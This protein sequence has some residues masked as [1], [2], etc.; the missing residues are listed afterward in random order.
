M[1]TQQEIEYWKRRRQQFTKERFFVANTIALITHTVTQQFDLIKVRSIMLQEGK[2][3]NGMGYTR[4]YNGFQLYREIVSQGGG[5]KKWFTSYE[6][7]LTRTLTYTTSRVWAYLYFYDR[8]NKDPR[9]HARPD[10]TAMAGV[11]GGVI[12]GIVSNPVEIVF[13]RMQV[14]DMYPGSYRR[15]YTS[16]YDGFLKTAQEGALFRGA[17]ANG[18]RI[19][20]MISCATGL[21]DWCKENAY[22]FLGPHFLNRLFGTLVASIVCTLA[23]MPFDTIRT[24]LYT[25]RALPNGKMPYANM[26]DCIS[27]IIK[28]E[29]NIKNHGNLTAFYAGSFAFLTRFLAITLVSQYLIDYYHFQMKKEELFIP[30]AYNHH[31]GKSYSQWEPMTLGL[32]KGQINRQSVKG[33]DETAAFTPNHK[34]MN[35]V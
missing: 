10:R 33:Y 21:H 7:F 3:Y 15:G 18:L 26:I 8:L 13:T 9:R 20:A 35:Y 23:V 27:K 6:G 2:T 29:A 12:A 34:P 30:Y 22:Y 25:M 14:E 5:Y 24:R 1:P 11:A 17:V 31:G 32:H 28:Y 4:G 19:S 16:F